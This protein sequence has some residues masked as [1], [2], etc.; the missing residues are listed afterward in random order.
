MIRRD[1]IGRRVGFNWW[2]DHNLQVMRDY[3][4]AVD[5]LEGENHQMEPEEFKQAH[6]KLTFK[7]CLVGNAGMSQ[8][9]DTR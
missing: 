5:S 8:D 2:R 9:P 6:P 1:K 7:Q 3:N 4:F